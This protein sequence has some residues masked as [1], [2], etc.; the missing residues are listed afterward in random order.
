[1]RRIL[2]C[3]GVLGGGSALVLA[4]AVAVTLLSPP[5]PLVPGGW[6]MM[7]PRWGMERGFAMPA[8]APAIS[9]PA[10]PI[11]DLEGRTRPMEPAVEVER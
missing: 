3:G 1:M 2:V 6:S 8:P 5:G 4:A 7:G 9:V 10:G 11:D